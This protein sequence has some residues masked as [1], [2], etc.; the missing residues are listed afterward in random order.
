[1]QHAHRITTVK[2]SDIIVELD[3][4]RIVKQGNYEKLLE[5][6]PSFKKM[7]RAREEEIFRSLIDSYQSLDSKSN[8]HNY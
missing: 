2:H 6:S 4:G 5:R 7:V 8:T 1:M 3:Q